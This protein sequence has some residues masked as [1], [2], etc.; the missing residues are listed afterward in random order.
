MTIT[1][2][3]AASLNILTAALDD[4]GADVAHS[5][6]QLAL[7]AAAAIPTYLGLSVVVPQ[8]DPRSP[9]PAWPWGRSPAT[10]VPRCT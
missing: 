7:Q 10:F 8:Y 9:S 2:A 5:L 4:P 3:M 1:A 6:H